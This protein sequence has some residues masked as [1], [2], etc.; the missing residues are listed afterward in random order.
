MVNEPSSYAG[1]E[2]EDGLHIQL[3]VRA[4]RVSESSVFVCIHIQCRASNSL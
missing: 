3:P 1:F 2:S 4:K